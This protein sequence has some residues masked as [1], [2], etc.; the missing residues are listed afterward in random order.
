MMLFLSALICLKR[1]RSF[2]PFSSIARVCSSSI[3]PRIPHRTGYSEVGEHHAIS[4]GGF[5][6][7]SNGI[8]KYD[9]YTKLDGIDRWFSG[10]LVFKPLTDGQLFQTRWKLWRQLPWKKIKGKVILKVQLSGSL[11]IEASSSMRSFNF[12]SSPNLALV[13]SLADMSKLLTYAAVDPRVLAIMVN[14][15]PLTCGYAKL[16]ELRRAMD[17]FTQS[18]KE[19]IGY[20]EGGSAKEYFIGLGCNEIFVPPEGNFD[21]RGFSASATFL[22]GLFDKVGIEPQVQR[23]GKY[24]S[25]GDTFNRDSISDA[26]REVISSLL[27]EASD[28]WL[29]R[30]AERRNKS[31]ESIISELWNSDSLLTPHDLVSK[32]YISGVKYLDQVELYLRSKYRTEQSYNIIK[33]FLSLVPG[34]V[35]PSQGVFQ[36]LLEQ[37]QQEM[38]NVNLSREFEGHPRR[39][40]EKNSSVASKY[41]LMSDT[42]VIPPEYLVRG[43]MNQSSKSSGETSKANLEK[44]KAAASMRA[45]EPNFIPANVYLKK[46]RRGDR[47]LEGLRVIETNRGPRIAIVNAVGAISTGRSGSS[48]LSGRTLGSDSLIEMVQRA[49]S[50]R[51]ITAVV[52][53]VDSPGGS[54]LASDLMW[55]ELRLLA[56][57]KPVVASM[58]DVAASGGYYLSMACDVIVAEDLTV[59]GSIGVV[60]A[61]FN[62]KELFGKIGGFPLSR[63]FSVSFR[64]SAVSCP[65]SLAHTQGTTWSYSPAADSP[66]SVCMSMSLSM[67]ISMSPV[68][69]MTR[70][71][72]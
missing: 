71:V 10:R 21:L 53:R 7:V 41:T 30:T 45:R 38:G 29:D 60:T 28:Y 16:I 8:V 37:E 5:P 1:V 39:A 24:K 57:E 20:C 9:G 33:E 44:Q 34:T 35:R 62:A 42:T 25:A 17:F 49:K 72:A 51:S 14:I 59:T 55:R 12:G 31:V 22:R 13:D 15:G 48:G 69:L 47:I 56:R 11:S 40:F 18:K 68:S 2:S 6:C 26:Q 36:E 23:L 70:L 3:F 52:L 32:G 46:M 63:I 50:D 61:K 58:V 67:S 54:A 4:D 19:I 27:M 65:R 64:L 43:G 66:R